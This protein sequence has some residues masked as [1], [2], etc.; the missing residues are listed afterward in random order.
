MTPTVTAQ[1]VRTVFVSVAGTHQAAVMWCPRDITCCP[2]QA[3]WPADREPDVWDQTGQGDWDVSSYVQCGGCG[4]LI[5][6][7]SRVILDPSD[8]ELAQA[9]ILVA[10]E[11]SDR[12]AARRS[13]L[14]VWLRESLD[15][16]TQ[17]QI[18]QLPDLMGMPEPGV[19][20]DTDGSVVAWD[21]DPAY[22]GDDSKIISERRRQ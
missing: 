12:D 5:M 6:P 2:G 10:E 4:S 1:D 9:R 19:G 13:R 18:R 21:Y 14:I 7:V 17:D 22:P 3:G 8:A 11:Q 16:L 20:L 15:E